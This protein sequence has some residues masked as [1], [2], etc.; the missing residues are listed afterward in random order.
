MR[1][2]KRAILMGALGLAAGGAVGCAEERAPINRV[3]PNALA[4]SFFVGALLNDRSDD[5]EF[6][7]QGTLV[8]VGYGAAQDGLFTSTYAQPLSRIKWVV[9]E[10]FLFGRITHER[11]DDSDGKGA[12]VAT[13]DGVIAYAYPII[14]HF[15]IRRAYNSTTGE[16]SN[17]VEENSSDRAWNERE[18][19]RVDWSQ[20]HATDSYDFDTLS[21]LG[22]YGSINYESLAYYINDPNSPDAP[23]FDPTTGY[24]DVTNKAFASPKLIDLSSFGWGID[25]F[26]ACFLDNDFMGGS[27]P[28]GNCNPVEITLRQSFRRVVDKD[29]EPKEWDGHRFQSYGAFDTERMGY[30]R[31]YGMS[32]DKWH[33]LITRYNL[34]NRSHAYADPATMT[35]PTVCYTPETTPIGADPHRDTDADGTED[36]CA[37]VGRGSRCDTFSQKCTL[38]YRDRTEAPQVWYYTSG[39]NN[40][41]FDGTDWA[42]H[43]WDVAL[44]VAVQTARYSECVSTGGGDCATTYP[45]YFGQEDDNWDVINLAREVDACRHGTAYAGQDCNAVADQVGSQR[46]YDPGVIAAAKMQEMIVLCHS[47]VESKDHA[48]CAPTDRRLP[49]DITA[50]QCADAREYYRV[51]G[52]A[53]DAGMQRVLDACDAA[54]NVR[55]GDLRYHQVNV[56]TAPQTPSPW[57]IYTDAED[58]LTGEKVSASINVWSH[59]NDLWSQGVVDT[60]RYIAGELKTSDVTEGTYVRDWAKANE[61]GSGGLALPGMS[62]DEVEKRMASA[63]GVDQTKFRDLSRDG[64]KNLDPALLQAAS[65]VRNK[66]R[67]VRADAKATSVA[68]PIYQQRLDRAKGTELE[69]ELMTP[70]MQQM[71]GVEGMPL[72]DAVMDVASPL[73]GAN[74]S[75]Q[76]NVR[77]LKEVALADRGACIMQ[78][79]PAPV[80]FA[81]L[82]DILQEKFGKFDASESKD[83]QVARGERMRKYLAQRAQ[84]AVIIHEMG[85]SVGMRHNFVSSSDAFNYRPQ[86]WQLRTKNGT[87]TDACADYQDDGSGCVGPRYFDPVT[88]EERDNLIWMW[89]QSSVMDYAGEA[90]QDLIGL[91]SYDFAAVRMFYGDA[92]AVH[93]DPSYNAE[94]N[95][96]I[97]MLAKMDNFG[98]I[99]GFDPQVGPFDPNSGG[100]R[101]FHYSEYHNEYEL[102]K[103]CETIADPQIFKPSD[104]NDERDGIWHPIIDGL[105]VEMDGVYSRCEQQKVDYIQWNQLRGP[106]GVELGGNDP[107]DLE[108]GI[109][110]SGGP[111]VDSKSGRTRVPYG[112][113]TDRWADLG[114]LSVYRHDN[115]ADPYELF[116][117]LI[118]QQEIGHIFDNY[119]RNRQSFSVR[120]AAGRR[121]GRYNEKMRDAAKG[122]GLLYNIYK[123]FSADAG[124]NFDDFWPVLAPEFFPENLI[125]SGIGFDHFSRQIQRP[126]PGP[127]YRPNG[128]IVLKSPDSGF[129]NGGV[130]RVIIPNGA[131]GYHEA[132]GFGGML[133]ENTL[134]TDKGEY[135]AS[136]TMNAG[137]YYDK[138]Y[139]TMLFA[140][141]VDNFISDSLTDFLDPRYRAVSLADLFPDGFRRMLANNLA[142]D[143]EIKGVRLVADS[144]GNP[145][146][147][148]TSTD[149]NPE[150]K[151]FPAQPI[152]WTSWWET[153]GPEVCFPATG[154]IV[155]SG[156]GAS[157]SNPFNPQ[158]PANTTIVDPQVGYEQQ[159]FL[160]AWTLAYILENDQKHWLD[161]MN[162]WEIGADTDPAFDNR[163]E[164]H[165]PMGQ[166]YVAKTFGV[167]DIFGKT[168]QKGISA[169]MLEWA[170]TLLEQA[171][172]VTAVDHDGD[173]VTDWYV[174]ILFNGQPHVK[175]DNG[176]DAI[177][178]N[179]NTLPSGKAGCNAQDNSECT[180]AANRACIELE[181]YVQLP[182][183]MRMAIRD[184]GFASPSMKGIY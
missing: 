23:Y 5:P 44:R 79:A 139:A 54:L 163:I 69:A 151:Q 99:L 31:N 183:F 106:N 141:S 73:R 68:K 140:E 53:M 71:T 17:V 88:P 26:P 98:G 70:M 51:N 128:Q 111:S 13:E 137:S 149:P 169:R 32:D 28:A 144:S 36:E 126:E 81:G 90:T 162:V 14:N 107:E 59:V 91:G 67:D 64:V 15:D 75:V 29:Y 65:K 143:E 178:P 138:V 179:G 158:A 76:R 157:T 154:S 161:M 172:D 173:G 12:G 82:G 37:S 43:E 95:R 115:G 129:T 127:H 148:T 66:M 119:R 116:N 84:Y 9:T 167:E 176:L 160:I 184:L 48:L 171:Y 114:N 89:S 170:N 72:N 22:V 42:A 11:I 83:V 102:I 56:M 133:M 105:I 104:W 180:C 20:N 2:W 136:Y 155:C 112:F 101:S 100:I 165:N 61:A 34:W 21:L 131:T 130:T 124:Y 168:V 87:V 153:S 146:L 117:F 110:Y 35:G 175:Y 86:Y 134:A 47:P 19:F 94:E 41:Y 164:F 150:A 33:R 8:D 58:P 1:M 52:R 125:A 78:E 174:P 93:A 45:M 74:P 108:S 135:D 16:E 57:G 60:L 113:A 62:K 147:D 152:G 30:A 132:V 92:V 181:K 97:G 122:L 156:Y 46:G 27:Y 120:G 121:L 3:Q 18:Y 50:N 4:K 49:S 142:D 145:E 123:D 109:F 63:V 118:S 24:F 80:S 177:G 103:N 55:M 39:S 38:P 6:W 40:D 182:Y 77:L 10:D 159:K 25:S 166:I 7:A 96:G 85:H